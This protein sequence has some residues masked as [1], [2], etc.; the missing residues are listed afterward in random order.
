MEDFKVTIPGY[1]IVL[2]EAQTKYKGFNT[3]TCLAEYIELQNAIEHQQHNLSMSYEAA[4]RKKVA[5]ELYHIYSTR[6]N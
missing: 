3:V 2:D 1:A 4:A 6:L 5:I